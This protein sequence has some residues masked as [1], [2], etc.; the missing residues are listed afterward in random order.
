VLNL[1]K[2]LGGFNVL[3]V[4]INE[5]RSDAFKFLSEVSFHS[6]CEAQELHLQHVTLQ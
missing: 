4:V 2:E 5:S 6:P 3:S 1:A